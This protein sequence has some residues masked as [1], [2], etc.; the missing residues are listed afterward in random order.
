ME[1]SADCSK[2]RECVRKKTCFKIKLDAMSTESS[3]RKSV[4]LCKSVPGRISVY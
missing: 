1:W 3:K 4:Q 2:K